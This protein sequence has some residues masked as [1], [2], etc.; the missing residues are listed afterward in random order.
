MTPASFRFP[1]HHRLRSPNDFRKTFD[2]KC[3]VSDDWLIVYGS[4]NDLDHCRLGLSVS[5]KAGNAVRRNRLRR[6]YKETFR[7]CHGELPPGLD[8]ILI[9]RQRPDLPTLEQL[10]QSLPRLVA[11]LARRLAAGKA[12]GENRTE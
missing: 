3:S 11:K 1:S 12:K 7:L 5:R 8:L 10:K 9:P 4:A 2:R 6:L